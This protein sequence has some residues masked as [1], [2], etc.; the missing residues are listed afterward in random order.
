[1]DKMTRFG[2][3]LSLL[4]AGT[5]LRGHAQAPS[6][7]ATAARIIRST[8]AQWVEAANRQDWRAAAAIWAP[9]LIGW[10]P[11]QPDD[12]YAKEMEQ[13][14]HPRPRRR[15]TRYDVIVNEVIVSGPLAVVRDTWRFTTGAGTPDSTVDVVRS[16][17]VW[18]RQ[19][20]GHWKI[21][22]WISAPEPK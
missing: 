21:A 22:R 10:Y 6:D 18:R 20:E 2:I 3:L 16:F 8:L 17:E 4:L 1:M 19:T 14:A 15:P 11:G 5:T 13:A 12:T 9:D 7:S